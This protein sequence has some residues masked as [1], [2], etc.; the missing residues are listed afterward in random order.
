M[1]IG[2]CKSPLS[3]QSFKKYMK[4]TPCPAHARFL[5]SSTR[6]ESFFHCFNALATVLRASAPRR[7]K[8]GVHVNLGRAHTAPSFF[9]DSMAYFLSDSSRL[10]VAVAATT[11]FAALL[12]MRRRR[13]RSKLPPG[14][15]LEP[16]IGGF[17]AM[18]STHQWK[19]FAEWSQK[20]GM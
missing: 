2:F 16:I 14:P 9:T 8:R 1:A 17:R 20:W 12:A 15:P 5:S 19:T 10:F 6:S 11:V 7:Y 4:R 18:P 13:L 3:I